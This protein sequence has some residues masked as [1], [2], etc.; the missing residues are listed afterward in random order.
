[1]IGG[2]LNSLA[3]FVSSSAYE[4]SFIEKRFEEAQND[5]N[6]KAIRAVLYEICP[7]RYSGETFKVFIGMGEVE[8]M[9][10]ET[11]FNKKQIVELLGLEEKHIDSLIK[12]VPIELKEQFIKGDIYLAIQNHCGVPTS[13]KG[14]F[15]RNITSLNESYEKYK[16]LEE[17]SPYIGLGEPK[18]IISNGDNSKVS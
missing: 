15:F 3:I 10:I 17:T 12:R 11:E 9:V 13:V 6:K 8:P 7:W 16:E 2:K 14:T 1:M 4:S 18:I 5:K